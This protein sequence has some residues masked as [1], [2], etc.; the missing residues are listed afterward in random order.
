MRRTKLYGLGE[1]D[2]GLI[3]VADLELVVAE[4][5]LCVGHAS[6]VL[7]SGRAGF[8]L[9][10]TGAS[11]R[12]GWC[13]RCAMMCPAVGGPDRSIEIIGASRGG[14]RPRGGWGLAGAA[15]VHF[16]TFRLRYFCFCGGPF[17]G[18]QLFGKDLFAFGAC[19]SCGGIRCPSLSSRPPAPRAKPLVGGARW[20][21]PVVSHRPLTHLPP[22]NQPH[23][24]FSQR[25][26]PP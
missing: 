19:A 25:W 14:G 18:A 24:R 22:Q 3:I 5:F 1:V 8:A 7:R 11:R 17:C 9:A 6:S 10:R 21:C 15:L 23:Y 20:H 13:R 12:H 26:R 2:D 4:R 16:R